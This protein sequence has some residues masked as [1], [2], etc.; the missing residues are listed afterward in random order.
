MAEKQKQ[1]FNDA[2]L[3]P[4]YMSPRDLVCEMGR[5]TGKGLI[6]AM[7]LIQVE[8]Q[9]P[10][11]CTGFVSPSYKKCLTST[12]PSLLVHWERW[13]YKR[14]IHYTVG[15][16]PWKA[17]KWKDPIFT[18]QNWENCIGFYNGSVC[19]IITQDREGASNGL[20]LDH[21]LIDEA[22]FVDYEKLKNETFQT[23][24]GNEM[25]FRNCH[26][27]HGMTITCDTATTKKGSWFMNYE[28]EQDREL[29]K[30]LEGM[31]CQHWKI[32][33]RMK[34]HPERFKYYQQELR[35]L[36]HDMFI[37]R[38]NCLLYCRYPSLFN[39]PILGLDFIKRMK[40]DLPA[41]TFATSIMCKHIGIMHDGF[42]GQLRENVNLYT[43][44]NVSRLTLQDIQNIENDCRL[45]ADRDPNAPLI[46]AFDAN[47]N[48]NWLVVGQVGIDGKLYVL[49]SFYVKYQT[50]D[51]V[52]SLF[53]EYYRHHKNRQVYFVFDSTFKG[54]GY[55]A[56]NNEDFYILISN[57]L[58]A[59][60]WLVEQVFIGNPMH[61][62]DKY[63]LINRM[64]VGKASHQ[65]FINRDNNEDLLLSIQTAAIYNEHKDKRGEK[66]AETEEDK[67]EA[68]TDGSDAFDT[69]CIGVEK[70]IP[71]YA[72]QQSMG[73][74]SYMG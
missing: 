39:L 45:D 44:P 33:Q 47:T 15:K 4:L 10:G 60:G 28:K 61:H 24:R 8:Q 21:I 54:Q 72:L 43:A 49:K 40:R 42:Y 62:V 74:V 32:R 16:K 2:Q 59:A 65:V 50:L 26:L 30:C 1:Y 69:L 9:M 25:Y 19:Q 7:R 71:A 51:A 11:S 18:P 53:T 12:L 67:L 34:Q 27:H 48:I 23:N 13:G 68:R 29:V 46:I 66:L 70:F 22:K 38:K 58:S 37:L 36:E 56:N 63:H 31:V 5:G 41:L 3:Y 57:L 14:D 35:R 64:L 73:W 55:G 20:S 6:D 52:V 17:L